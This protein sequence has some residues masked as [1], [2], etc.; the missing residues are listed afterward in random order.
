MTTPDSST[1]LTTIND[2]ARRILDESVSLLNEHLSEV[3]IVGGW[4][5]FLRNQ[6]RHPGTKD[7]DILFPPRYPKE[8]AADVIARFLDNGYMVSAKHGFQILKPLRVGHRNYLFN[9]DFL[10]PAIERLDVME[11]EDVINLD[12]TLDGTIVKTVQ[13]AGILRGDLVFAENLSEVV[14]ITDRDVRFLSDTGVVTT[15]LK[16]A[17][18]PKRRRDIYDVV[19]AWKAS[20]EEVTLR[21]REMSDEYEIVSTW[22]R[23]FAVF[24][25]KN[26]DFFPEAVAE[27]SRVENTEENQFALNQIIEFAKEF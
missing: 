23:E 15:K 16:S 21:L 2:G 27:F 1:P 18:N 20:Y 6:D 13:T 9:V 22:L 26:P 8:V 17:C 3:V 12:V 14:S 24:S 4:G 19:L 11:F 7:V 10:H 5:I 25:G